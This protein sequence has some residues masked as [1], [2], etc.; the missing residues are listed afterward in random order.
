MKAWLA[1]CGAIIVEVSASLSLK[2]AL[3]YPGLYLI[4]VCGYVCAF[5][6]LFVSLRAGMP[7]GVGYGVWGASGVALT[8]L[9]SQLLFNE[10][11]TLT[12]AIGI[13][14]V[15]IGV[16]L[17]ELGSGLTEAKAS[18]KGSCFETGEESSGQ[19]TNSDARH[20]QEAAA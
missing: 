11:I 9:L 19:E 6:L 7:L 8:A 17:V 13:G 20:L 2:G 14:L 10:P 4:V 15:V 5:A 16:L 1:L 3:D 18:T 12:M